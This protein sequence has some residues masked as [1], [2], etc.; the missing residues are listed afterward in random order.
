MCPLLIGA[1]EPAGKS[2]T[3][4][5]QKAYNAAVAKKDP[6]ERIAALEKFTAD[7]PHYYAIYSRIL[8]L[9]TMVKEWPGDQSRIQAQIGKILH[10][11]K[12]DQRSSTEEQIAST[13][14]DE[15][16]ML[17]E[18]ER[19]AAISI[20]SFKQASFVQE[21]KANAIKRKRPVPSDEELASRYRTQL[22]PRQETLGL[23]LYKEGRQE[24]AEKLLKT[25]LAANPTLW[26]S[27][28]RLASIAQRRNDDTAALDY[29]VTVRLFGHADAAGLK[30]MEEL[31]SKLHGS[32]ISMDEYLDNAYRQRFPNPLK[33]EPYQKTTARSDRAVLAEVFTGAGCP[34]CVAA[35]LAMDAALERYARKDVVVLM[36]HQHIPKPDPM[37]N[38]ST[39][40]RAKF[41]GLRA[42]P[43][44]SIDGKLAGSLQVADAIRIGAKE[45]IGN[46]EKMGLDVVL[47]TGDRK[48]T[49]EAVARE[50]G[51]D[52]VVAGVLPD[53]KVAEIRRL[54]GDGRVVAM[55]GDGINDAPALAQADAGFAMGSGTDIA[56]EASDVTLLHSDLKG[57]VQAV[58]LSR[59][60]WRVMRQNLFW[61]LAYNVVAIPAAALGFLN[62]VIA[63]A[64]MA[65]SSVSVVFN[66]LRLKRIKL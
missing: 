25:A 63:S 38:P 33:V 66:S 3:P 61:A 17:A 8:I 20:K 34:P 42:V 7:F 65:A 19:H 48:E 52:R 37:A 23:I 39:L 57:I 4:P 47:L 29:M 43:S 10:V 5:D 1:Q 26:S 56:I 45:A 13:L 51:I 54:Q 2:E 59:A 40:A 32:S 53:G 50:A 49:A 35:D 15:N 24:Q 11:A 18:A 46:L 22:A 28:S 58:R 64:A 21:Q 55:A 36:Y 44:Y 41:Y 6:V 62:P 31:Y 12:K 27:A 16:A 60:A 30:R 9:A 14:L